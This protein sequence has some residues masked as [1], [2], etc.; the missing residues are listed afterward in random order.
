M[1]NNIFFAAPGKLH[2]CIQDD[3]HSAIGLPPNGNA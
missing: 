1:Q 2:S 3:M